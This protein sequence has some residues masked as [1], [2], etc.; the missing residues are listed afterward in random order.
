MKNKGRLE[1]IGLVCSD[2]G[3]KFTW[4]PGEQYFYHT[5]SLAPPHRCPVC[6]AVRKATL[7]DTGGER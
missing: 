2:C 5:H 1:P 4:E 7:A 3:S 6:R